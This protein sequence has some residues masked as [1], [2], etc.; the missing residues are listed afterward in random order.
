MRVYHIRC[1]CCEC[2][3]NIGKGRVYITFIKDLQVFM[4]SQSVISVAGMQCR[5]NTG[6][7]SVWT[8]T[9][10]ILGL[11]C[12]HRQ[13]C[14]MFGDNCSFNGSGFIVPLRS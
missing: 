9:V 13:H 11:F 5:E 3:E 6:I 10:T 14:G 12:Q 8:L 7:L 2:R 4:L 1:I